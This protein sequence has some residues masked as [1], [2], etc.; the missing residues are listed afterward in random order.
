MPRPKVMHWSARVNHR[1]MGSYNPKEDS[2][3][4]NCGLDRADVPSYVLDFIMYHEL[5]HKALGIK[6]SGSR[7]M[8]HT[9]EFRKLEQAHPDYERAE[10]FL[11]KLVKIL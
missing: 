9:A 5:L 11:Q 10:A 1:T 7:R 8:A 3:M 2:L 6:T 4:I